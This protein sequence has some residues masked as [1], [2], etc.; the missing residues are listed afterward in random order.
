MTPFDLQSR[1]E[2]ERVGH[3]VD[4]PSLPPDRVDDLD[5][6]AG[7]SK[8]PDVSRLTAAAC[9]EDRAV[10]FDSLGRDADDLPFGGRSIGISGCDLFG[11]FGWPVA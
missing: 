5:L 8:D 6:S 10:E 4:D 1:F 9:V 7:V 3:D 2:T 11:H